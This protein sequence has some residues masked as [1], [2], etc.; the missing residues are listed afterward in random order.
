[1]DMCVT[2]G[3]AFSQAHSALSVCRNAGR[4][5]AQYGKHNYCNALSNKYST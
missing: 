5:L 3:W 4:L 1:M 2:Y